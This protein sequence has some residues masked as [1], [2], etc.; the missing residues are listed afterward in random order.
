MDIVRL[1][2]TC[3]FGILISYEATAGTYN[4]LLDFCVTATGICS[5]TVGASA[6]LLAMDGSGNLYGVATYE[7]HGTYAL[8]IVYELVKGTSGYSYQELYSFC[9][10]GG[11]CSDGEFPVGQLV[12]DSSGNLYGATQQGGALGYGSI[13]KLSPSTP[14]WQLTTIW[15]FCQTGSCSKGSN[16]LVGLTYIGAASGVYYDGTSSLFGTTNTGGQFGSGTV[17]ELKTPAATPS[18]RAI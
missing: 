12:I 5:S 10:S 9:S 8:G 15:S 11:A 13:Y 14:S 18:M 6:D 1:F 3:L 16:P 7:G 17:Y 4:K 2:A